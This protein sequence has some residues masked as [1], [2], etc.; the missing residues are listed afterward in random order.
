MWFHPLNSS[1]FLEPSSKLSSHPTSKDCYLNGRKTKL[2]TQSQSQSQSQS[3]GPHSIWGGLLL[4]G[5][6]L[7]SWSCFHVGTFLLQPLCIVRS[8][9]T[10]VTQQ[11]KTAVSRLGHLKNSF[12]INHRALFFPCVTRELFSSQLWLGVIVASVCMAF[13]FPIF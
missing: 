8:W 9:R 3:Q 1:H 12:K 5:D 10:E 13:R 11:D 7:L 2:R 6:W 4:A